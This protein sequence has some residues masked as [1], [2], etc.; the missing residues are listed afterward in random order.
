MR[1][2]HLFSIIM[3]VLA[4]AGL[5]LSGCMDNRQ[6]DTGDK[7]IIITSIATTAYFADRIGGDRVEVSSL[8]PPGASPH[9]YE[10][11][12]GQLESVSTA[13]MFVKVG[14]GIEF[15]L[16]W[17]D[18]IIEMNG[19]MLVTDCSKNIEYDDP[20][21]WLSP[22]N[23]EVMAQNIC[24]G[25]VE[26][27]PDNGEYYRENLAGLLTEL[28]SLDAY[29]SQML[30]GVTNRNILVQHPAWSCFTARYGLEEIAIEEEG[31]EPTLKGIEELITMAKKENIKTVFA[32][33][34]FSTKSAEAVAYEI[35][36]KVVL[37]S[38]LP[39]D[40]ITD[41]EKAARIFNEN[42]E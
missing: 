11:T 19:N 23:A 36:G 34:E 3:A 39:Q 22:V 41:M 7:V 17:I 33:P 10:P 16:E 28:D 26:I 31:K 1:K 37:V 2:N 4:V 42:M 40:Y 5:L 30:S 32:S 35:G 20:H 25:L 29:I 18:K 14:S 24:D 27:D 38:P 15:E 6:D 8:I 12:P 21:I 9:S 13:D